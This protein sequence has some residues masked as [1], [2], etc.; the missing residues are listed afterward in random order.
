[1]LESTKL[2]ID[3]DRAATLSALH[4]AHYLRLVRVAIQL[5]DDQPSAED[6]V[7]D[8]FARLHRSG[9][10]LGRLDDP[11]RYLTTA[12]VNQARSAL[13]HRR[14]VRIHQPGRALD[15]MESADAQVIRDATSAL[16]WKAISRLPSRQK[17]VVVL[18][19]YEDWSIPEIATAL[20]ISRGAASS[21]LD[22]ALKSL[23]TPIG[24]LDA[25]H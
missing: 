24:G 18:R 4:R 22:R 25:D 20:G 9:H 13:R 7:Q 11:G 12:V 23:A 15:D 3:A 17:Q 5:I 16:V 2:G 6:L 8:V 21:S 14:V 19:Y 1:M 10:D